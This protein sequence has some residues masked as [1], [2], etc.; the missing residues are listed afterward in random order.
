MP[1]FNQAEF[2]YVY[3]CIKDTSNWPAAINRINAWRTRGKLSPSIDS[4]CSLMEALTSST[5]H[6]NE[7][8]VLSMAFIRFFNS[9][10]DQGQTGKFAQ[11]VSAIAETLGLPGW[12]V[13]LRHAA[14]HD[15]LP[16]L[17]VLVNGCT[18]ALEWLTVNY[19]QKMMVNAATAVEERDVDAVLKK[20]KDDRRIEIKAKDNTK[21]ASVSIRALDSAIWSKSL[22]RSALVSNIVGMGYLIPSSKS[23]RAGADFELPSTSLDLWGPLLERIDSAHDESFLFTL[24][25]E[26]VHVLYSSNESGSI[27]CNQT[28]GIKFSLANSLVAWARQIYSKYLCNRTRFS[29]YCLDAVLKSPESLLYAISIEINSCSYSALL[30]L[31]SSDSALHSLTEYSKALSLKNKK[32]KKGSGVVIDMDEIEKRSLDIGNI[33]GQAGKSSG[34]WRSVKDFYPCAIGSDSILEDLN[35]SDSFFDSQTAPIAIKQEVMSVERDVK[36]ENRVDHFSGIKV[37]ELLGKRMRI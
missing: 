22:T 23:Q 12:F 37:Q 33:I 31:F 21:R 32:K 8:R 1:F 14:T 10:V 27:S 35:L 9:L 4:T 29:Q 24:F 2:E 3:S 20:Y 25:L 30:S 16:C 5:S 15:Y 11:S 6:N 17:P 13:D 18:Q 28:L 19:W 7:R 34:R 26:I 36:E